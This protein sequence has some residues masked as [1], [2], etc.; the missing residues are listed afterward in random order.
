MTLKQRNEMVSNK[1]IAILQ[2]EGYTPDQML[3]V[4]ALSRIKYKLLK[5]KRNEKSIS[6]TSKAI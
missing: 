6:K 3:K 5:Q 2:K 1:M 4:I